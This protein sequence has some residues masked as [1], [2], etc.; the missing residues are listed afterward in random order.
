M[1]GDKVSATDMN[2]EGPEGV[3][4]STTRRGEDVAKEEGRE[5]ETT[6]TKGADRPVGEM[7]EQ[8]GAMPSKTI[9]EDMPDMPPADGGR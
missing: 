2:P 4:D 5:F 8:P 7:K 9:D 1:E 6:G 3:G